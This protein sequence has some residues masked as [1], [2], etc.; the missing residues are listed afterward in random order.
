MNAQFKGNMD[1]H[2]RVYRIVNTEKNKKLLTQQQRLNK[3]T[4][5]SE[6]VVKN[7]K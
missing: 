5:P 1:A 2:I 4:I 6:I 3:K 7:K